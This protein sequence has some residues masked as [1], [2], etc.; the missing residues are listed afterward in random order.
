MLSVPIDCDENGYRA[1]I[2]SPELAYFFKNA[3]F[4]SIVGVG[5]ECSRRNK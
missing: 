1:D 5:K 4:R 2:N 3:Q